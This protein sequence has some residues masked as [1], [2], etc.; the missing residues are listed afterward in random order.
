MQ[1]LTNHNLVLLSRKIRGMFSFPKGGKI[2]L[3]GLGSV[4]ISVL[5]DARSSIDDL[6][7]HAVLLD[8]V[9]DG[10]VFGSRLNPESRN[11]EFFGFLKDS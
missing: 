6:V 5:Q 11:V 8:K 1:E 7:C 9:Y 4:T 10:L 2:N 3:L